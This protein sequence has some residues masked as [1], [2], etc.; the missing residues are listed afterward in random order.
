MLFFLPCSSPTI[1]RDVEGHFKFEGCQMAKEKDLI[2]YGSRAVPRGHTY[3][4]TRRLVYQYQWYM[5]R[6]F[7]VRKAD[8]ED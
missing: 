2:T 1:L 3:V 4:S 7:L 5:I 6:H 8:I